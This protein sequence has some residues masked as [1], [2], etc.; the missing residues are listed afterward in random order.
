VAGTITAVSGLSISVDTASTIP[1]GRL[2]G[3]TIGTGNFVRTISSHV[4]DNLTV[5]APLEGAQV[6]GSVSMCMGCDKS[7]V[8]CN[9]WHN[10]L[11]NFG[12]EP[13][14][15]GKNPFNGRMT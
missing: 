12:G 14:I 13:Y 6:G 3:G 7:V 9:A 1:D 10:N 11:L 5:I 15:A 2:I 8:S 4:G